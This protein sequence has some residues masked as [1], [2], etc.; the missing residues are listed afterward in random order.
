MHQLT[1]TYNWIIPI[2]GKRFSRLFC[3][4]SIGFFFLATS[5]VNAFSLV[6][7]D[8]SFQSIRT[9]TAG[10]FESHSNNSGSCP[11]LLQQC[12]PGS[13]SGT[14]GSAALYLGTSGN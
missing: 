12:H 2:L 13:G 9:Y 3:F 8:I 11:Q 7:L 5:S 10:P 6:F 14:P 1:F 4:V